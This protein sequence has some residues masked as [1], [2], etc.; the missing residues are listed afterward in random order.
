MSTTWDTTPEGEALNQSYF[1]LQ[2]AYQA[3]L[4]NQNQSLANL[5][6]RPITG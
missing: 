5:A 2:H 3:T 1:S 6:D 4:P